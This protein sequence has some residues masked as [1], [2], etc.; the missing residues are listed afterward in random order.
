MGPYRLSK[1][2]PFILICSRLY[3][4]AQIGHL[5]PKE[6]CKLLAELRIECKPPSLWLGRI[7]FHGVPLCTSINVPQSKNCALELAVSP[8][9]V[10]WVIGRC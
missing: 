6:L 7:F 2:F 1:W 10:L 9:Q 5:L 8:Q 3:P 4:A